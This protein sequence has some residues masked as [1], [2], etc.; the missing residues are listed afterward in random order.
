MNAIDS[1][2]IVLFILA[3]MAITLIIQC[4]IA[5]RYTERFESHLPNCKYITDNKITYK[6]GGLPGK[7]M[8]TGSI[9]IVLAIPK[10]F[11]WRRVAQADEVKD[12]PLR[13]RCIL[14]SL[15]ALQITLFLALILSDIL[16][17]T[18]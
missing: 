18:L 1:E 3:P 13:E 11:I 7:L 9:S 16:S 8:R 12:F 4:Y 14:L 2:T 6:H 10:L 17:S 15:L 5:H